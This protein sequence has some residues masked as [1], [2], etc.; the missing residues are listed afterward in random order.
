M[1]HALHI[2]VDDRERH[3]GVCEA[4]C[5]RPEVAEVTVARLPLGDYQVDDHLL[6]ERKTLRDFA[7]S[8]V[9]GR[10]F[11]QATRLANFAGEAALILEGSGKDAVGVNV[12]RHAM[13]GALIHLSLVLGLPVLRA[14]HPEETAD[15]IVYCGGQLSRM[16]RGE[17]KRTGW[18]PNQKRRRQLL[19][20]Q[21][22]PGIGPKR[23]ERLIDR[24]KSI[25]ALAQAPTEDLLAID[26]IG[27]ELAHL[28]RHTLAEPTAEYRL[29]TAHST[30]KDTKEDRK[31]KKY[32]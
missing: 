7:A 15:L 14:L 32:I 16:A 21:A 1:P 30:T 31:N 25:A 26:G 9:D 2:I 3:A 17:V 13:Q 22:I 5:G 12:P 10:L 19:M 20:L 24:F 23:A 27:E 6:V 4:L 28:I 18:K 8:V 11:A 29:G